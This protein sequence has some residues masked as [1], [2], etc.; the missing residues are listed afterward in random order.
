M[1]LREIKITI[2]ITAF[3]EKKLL[4]EAWKSILNQSSEHWEAVMVLDGGGDKQTKKCFNSINHPNLTQV[5]FSKNMGAYN[6]RTKAIELSKTDWYFHLDADDILPENAIDIVIKNILEYPH[7]EYIAGAC[8]NFFSGPD[9]IMYP[10]DN[11]EILTTRPLFIATSPIKISLFKKLGGYYIPNNFFHS[12]WDFW[13]SVYEQ[14]IKG[15]K[16]NEVI[17]NRRRRNNSLTWKNLHNL[18][19]GLEKIIMRHPDFFSINNRKKNARYDLYVMLAR[20]YK[21]IGKRKL[22]LKCATRALEYGEKPPVFDV[23]IE[24][25][26]M[27]IFRYMLRRIGKYLNYK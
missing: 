9:Q 3:N 20:H 2:G 19:Q 18:P 16:I 26:R 11:P 1:E 21:S 14:K 15:V 25:M 24:E 10:E 17:Y 6:C 7:V 8:K 12:D 4:L 22:A 13:L 27:N 5:S 23:A